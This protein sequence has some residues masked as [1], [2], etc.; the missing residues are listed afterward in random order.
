MTESPLIDLASLRFP[1]LIINSEL[2]QI[3]ETKPLFKMAESQCNKY[4]GDKVKVI[5]VLGNQSKSNKI[6][7]K[8][9]PIGQ[10]RVL[11]DTIVKVEGH[12]TRQ[13]T[14]FNQRPRKSM[15]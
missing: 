15:E 12:M 7:G 6:W 13:S 5:L 4:M 2:P 9:L 3:Q 11:N 1:H 8:Q 14:Q 10:V